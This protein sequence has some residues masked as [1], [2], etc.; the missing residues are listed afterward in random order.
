[1][2]SVC[3]LCL[4]F[5]VHSG[6]DCGCFSQACETRVDEDEGGHKHCT[7]Q[8]FDYWGCIDKCVSASEILILLYDFQIYVGTVFSQ[9]CGS[10]PRFP[11]CMGCFVLFVCMFGRGPSRESV[12]ER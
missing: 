9:E 1:M 11:D 12:N 3:D 2:S 6:V 7:G 10:W 8:Y 5:R 4:A